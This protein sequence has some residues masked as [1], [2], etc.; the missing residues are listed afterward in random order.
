MLIK[1][2]TKTSAAYN[3]NLPIKTLLSQISE[4]IAYTEA[5]NSKFAPE[6]ILTAGVATVTASG[7]S[8]TTLRNGESNQCPIKLMKNFRLSS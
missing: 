7:V 4:A 6:Q 5:G 3:L 2:Q 8:K 1:N